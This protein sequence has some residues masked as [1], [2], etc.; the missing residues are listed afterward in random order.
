M[1]ITIPLVGTQPPFKT[2]ELQITQLPKSVHIPEIIGPRRVPTLAEGAE[3]RYILHLPEGQRIAS[4]D[5]GESFNPDDASWIGGR[6]HTRESVGMWEIEVHGTDKQIYRGRLDVRASKLDEDSF[7]TML[8]QLAELSTEVLHQG[9]STAVGTYAPTHQ[10]APLL[11]YQRFAVLDSLLKSSDLTESIDFI[12]ARPYQSWETITVSQY[13]GQP[14]AGSSY[15]MRQVARPG[16]RVRAAGL[17]VASLPKA[18]TSL[19]SVETFD[20]APNRHIKFI[21]EQW[22]DLAQSISTQAASL[23]K[24]PRIRGQNRARSVVDYLDEILNS[25]LFKSV[26]SPQSMSESNTVLRFRD[27][28]RQ[29]MGAAAVVESNLGLD[30]ELEDPLLVSRR[31]IATLYELWA[32][33]FL[34]KCL[35]EIFDQ[36]VLPDLFTPSEAGMNLL[37]KPNQKE[38]LSFKAVVHGN[39]IQA[40]LFFNKTFGGNGK[41]SDGRSWTKSMRPDASLVIR[42]ENGMQVWLH[43]D[44]KYKIKWGDVIELE[45]GDGDSEESRS[46]KANP[47]DLLK[48]HAYRDGIWDSAGSYV[49]FPGDVPEK[50][51]KQAVEILP[52]IGAF[53]LRPDALN[54]DAVKLKSFISRSIDH[55]LAEG[56]RN[57]RA[58]FWTDLAYGQE[59]TELSAALPP[60]GGLPPADTPVCVCFVRSDSH[61]EWITSNGKY[62]LRSGAR[63]GSV[64]HAFPALDARLLLL[65]SS[66]EDTRQLRLFRRESVWT[67]VARSEMVDLGY[68]TPRG[69]AYLV[70]ELIPLDNQ[71]DWLRH[72]DP[73]TLSPSGSIHGAPFASTW[74]D[75]VL[76]AEANAAVQ[77]PRSFT[78]PAR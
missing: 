58:T 36:N 78:P 67:A 5:P 34:S 30:S 65:W 47:T 62:N 49:L 19:R 61:W 6:I 38:V 39:T 43:F 52:G 25:S 76:A 23:G 66:H 14:I 53:S 1:V 41:R 29:I 69:D 15:L 46:K 35:G 28:Y 45:S 4:I 63:T 75:L 70:S 26:G 21:L 18:L 24:N 8:A 16:P 64:T 48:M 33:V 55:L 59:G 40:D 27:G 71:P 32:F 50:F 10:G 57:H 12:L 31:S 60:M 7:A 73:E 56:T 77:R 68:P 9:F 2:G 74:L 37:L 20:N 11:E 54:S 3:Y 51:A 22:R 44:A 42:R 17:P 13:A 72:V